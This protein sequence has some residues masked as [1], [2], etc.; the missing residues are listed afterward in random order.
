M[1]NATIFVSVLLATLIFSVTDAVAETEVY[2]WVDEDGVVHFGDNA[3]G[4]KGAEKVEI[5][6][7]GNNGLG[8]NPAP[9][10]TDPG[11]QTEPQPSL[12]QQRREERAAKH[13]EAADRQKATDA[14]CAQARQ[15]V[16][17]LEPTPR[18]LVQH[19]DGSVDR[20][21]DNKRLELL[22]DAKTFI[23]ENCEK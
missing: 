7:E 8:T 18:V 11:Q 17:S 16:A 1:R 4:Q 10:L 12:A 19:E 20:L 5:R 6:A 23:A 22:A 2:R 21:D 13:R 9:G 14:G 15:R 3:E